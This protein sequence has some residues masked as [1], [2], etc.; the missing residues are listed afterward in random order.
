MPHDCQCQKDTKQMGFVS[1]RTPFTPLKIK[2]IKGLGEIDLPLMFCP[3]L[4]NV[5]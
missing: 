3:V 4:R 1:L 2:N 5:G